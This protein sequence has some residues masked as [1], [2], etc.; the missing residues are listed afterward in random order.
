M[1]G[2]FK[3]IEDM[4]KNIDVEPRF[5]IRSITTQAAKSIYY[6]PIICS[7]T[8]SPN[9]ASMIA[10]NLE[11]SYM[12]FVQACFALTPAVAVK[13]DKINVEEYLKQFH[14]NVGIKSANELF[15]TLKESV[16]EYKMFPN[17]VLNESVS[18][19]DASKILSNIGKG[20]TVD[21]AV[22]DATRLTKAEKKELFNINHARRTTAQDAKKL[23]SMA[24]SVCNVEVT[25]LLH[26]EP[27]QTKVPVG[28]KTLVHPCDAEELSGQIMDSVAGRGVFH[29]IVKYTTGEVLSL[30]D[31]LFGI[32]KMKKNISKSSKST[33]AKWFDIVDHRKRLNKLSMPFLGKKPFL[34]NLTINISMEDVDTIQRLIGYNLL[35]DT[36]RASKFITDNFLLAF[37]ITD[38]ATETAYILYDGHSDYEE[39]P[40]NSLKRDNEKVNDEI[41][42]MIK[43]LGVGIKMS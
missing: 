14:Q 40:Y 10:K 27:I 39:Y 16:E 42:A 22:K 6:F 28:V 33:V 9:T 2:T 36:Y 23:N 21:S 25:F 41:N 15:L 24:P 26:G 8:V 30:K 5:A 34:P 18:S 1:S 7:Q 3:Q 38:D 37:V 32:S 35:T 17:E 19:K 13:G 31:I 43:G 12:T 29:N 4:A 20:W 11:H